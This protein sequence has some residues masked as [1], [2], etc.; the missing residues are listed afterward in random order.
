MRLTTL[1]P[2]YDSSAIRPP[3]S[4][5]LST[6]AAAFH[7]LTKDHRSIARGCGSALGIE[8][9]ESF[10]DAFARLAAGESGSAA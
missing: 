8:L 1:S 5:L 9:S 2:K 7:A 4:V 6:A 3:D 10:S